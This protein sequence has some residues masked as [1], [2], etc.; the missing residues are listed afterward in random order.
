M[1]NDH[2][3]ISHTLSQNHELKEQLA[4][5]QDGLIKLT[6]DRVKLTS[7][8]HSEQHIEKEVAK[9]PDYLQETL[10]DMQ[11]TVEVKSQE[12]RGLQE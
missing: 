7:T 10:E 2:I 6:N 11:E 4:E 3:T 8:L 12:A 5:S 1:E 9:K